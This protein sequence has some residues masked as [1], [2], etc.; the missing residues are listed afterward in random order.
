MRLEPATGGIT[1]CEEHLRRTLA[2]CPRFRAW[3]GAD[4]QAQALARIHFDDLPAPEDGAA[5]LSE[6]QIIALRPFALIETGKQG[7]Y[8]RGRVATETYVEA[9]LLWIVLEENVPA[10]LAQHTAALARKFK[11]TL[12]QI[13][14]ELLALAYEP[15]YLAIDQ[16]TLHGPVRCTPETIVGEGDHQF[17]ALEVRHGVGQQ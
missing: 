1:L 3:C 4:N 13:I 8:S 15:D 2:D 6:D 10:D 5:A 9:G 17:A 16:L 7:G 14:A 11:N 12:G